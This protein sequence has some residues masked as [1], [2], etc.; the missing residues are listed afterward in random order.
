[1][2]LTADIRKGEK[3]V[4]PAEVMEG[5]ALLFLASYDGDIRSLCWKLL[6]IVRALNVLICVF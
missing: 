3:E 2:W 5:T 1:M 6:R 4:C